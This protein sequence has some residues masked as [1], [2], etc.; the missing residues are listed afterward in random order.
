[1][2]RQSEAETKERSLAELLIIVTLLGLLM[3]GFVNYY[4]KH[5]SRITDAGVQSLANRFAAH[6][7]AIHGQWLMDGRPTQVRLKDSSGSIAMI[8]VNQYGWPDS[9]NC[10]HIW[11]Q[12]L[13][14]PLELL[15]QP[16][17]VIELNRNTVDNSKICR[18]SISSE[19][20]FDY[21]PKSGKVIK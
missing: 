14:M 13:D 16:V 20:Y 12:V 8:S 21:Y 11:Q 5:G 18:F 15:K 10:Q 9:D 4:F 6:I 19:K 2:T 1:M 7:Q 17:A 3:A